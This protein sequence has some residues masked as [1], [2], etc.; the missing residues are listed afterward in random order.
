MDCEAVFAAGGRQV[1]Q[2]IS[3]TA[4]LS[5]QHQKQPEERGGGTKKKRRTRR[6][7]RQRDGLCFET[8]GMGAM[9]DQDHHRATPQHHHKTNA[10]STQYQ[11][12]KN[13][14]GRELQERV[15]KRK[16][17][18]GEGR[19]GRAWGERDRGHWSAITHIKARQPRIFRKWRPDRTDLR[20]GIGQLFGHV[21]WERRRARGNLDRGARDMRC[22]HRPFG[23]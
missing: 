16:G 22:D 17:R 1:Q 2:T 10:T 23:K 21:V 18:G 19:G 3:I 8:K 12:E 7:G 4:T 14:K 15:V 20:R 6:R 5:P 13:E 11:Q 9:G